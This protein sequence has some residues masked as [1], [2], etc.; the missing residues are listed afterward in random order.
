MRASERASADDANKDDMQRTPPMHRDFKAVDTHH[1]GYLTSD[2]V[3][4][5]DYVSNEGPM[6]RKEYANCHE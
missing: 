4:N 1:R 6:S 3:K 2:D 5:D